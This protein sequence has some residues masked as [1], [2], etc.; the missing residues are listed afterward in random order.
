MQEV[1][2]AQ[3][4]GQVPPD[5]L[6]QMSSQMQMAIEKFSSPVLAQLTQELLESIGQGDET[7]PLVQIREQE[8]ALKEKE[9]DADNQQ[10]ESKQQQRLQEKLL[11]NEIAKQRLGVQ[12]DVADDKLDVAIRRLDQQAE[13]KLLDMQ[14][15]N[16][17]GR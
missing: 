11:E 5:Q 15:K 17:G 4:S 13:L 10:F 9:I 6:Q 8:L 16:M 2:Q 14:N 1:Q 7:D 3:Q 12:K